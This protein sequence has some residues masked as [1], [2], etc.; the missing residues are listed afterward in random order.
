MKWELEIPKLAPY[1]CKSSRPVQFFWYSSSHASS[2][3][4]Y[5]NTLHSTLCAELRLT[6]LGISSIY[7]CHY[8][9]VD[10]VVVA[11]SPSASRNPTPTP[12]NSPTHI[13]GLIHKLNYLSLGFPYRSSPPLPSRV[14]HRAFYPCPLH[15]G[16]A[17]TMAAP[18]IILTTSY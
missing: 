1:V 15:A 6:P 10:P 11:S 14:H 3:K 17:A 2:L 9:L 12:P 8:S 13:H 7:T 18:T 5:I 4:G 16:I